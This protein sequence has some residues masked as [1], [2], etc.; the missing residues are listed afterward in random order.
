MGKEKKQQNSSAAF[1]VGAVSLAFLIL[2]YQAAIFVHRA[3]QLR[4]EANRDRP[5]TVY[6]Y[7][8]DGVQSSEEAATAATTVRKGEENVVIRKERHEAE[9]TPA[10]E[11]IRESTRR[12]ESFSFNPNTAGMEEFRRL[13]FS[14]KQAQAIL[15]YREKGGRFRRRQDFARSFAVSDSVYARLEPFIDIPLLDINQA[16]SAAFDALPGIGPWYASKMVEYR[17][18]IGGYTSTEQLMDIERFDSERY[19]ALCDLVTCGP[20]NGDGGSE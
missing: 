10:V 15:N 16:D 8:H 13:G 11:K 9:H 14:E 5:D 12:V 3:A 2:G 1:K 6:V 18:K 7:V 19:E 17:E 20:R 4:I